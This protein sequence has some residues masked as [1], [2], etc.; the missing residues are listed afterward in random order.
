MEKTMEGYMELDTYELQSL[1]RR[2]FKKISP[3]SSHR[4]SYFPFLGEVLVYDEKEVFDP[5][6]LS[7]AACSY[8]LSAVE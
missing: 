4:F 6:S 1:H 7:F 8:W 5:D 2:L 3:F